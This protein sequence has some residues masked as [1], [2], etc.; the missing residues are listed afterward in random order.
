MIRTALF[1][2]DTAVLVVPPCLYCPLQSAP[3]EANRVQKKKLWEAVQPDLKTSEDCVAGYK[4]QPM[5]TS[6]GPVTAKSLAK[7]NIA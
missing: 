4:G 3:A 1:V 5:N 2:S 6:A 7:A